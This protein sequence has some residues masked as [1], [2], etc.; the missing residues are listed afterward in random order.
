MKIALL[1]PIA[2]RTPPRH[3]GPWERV[4]S[5]LAEGLLEQGVE[6]T[7]FATGDSITKGKLEY[8]CP[9]PYE[10]NPQI[11]AKVWEYMHIAHLFEKAGQFDLI[12]NHYDFMPL[13]FCRL[14]S[15]PM[16]TT[17]HGFSSVKILPIY[18]E[19]NH[20]NYYISISNADRAPSL[21]YLDT[22]YHGLDLQEFDLVESP[23]EDLVFLGRIHPDKGTEEAIKI[24]QR[25]GRR[26]LIAG[27]I[28][29]QNYYNEI[30]VPQIDGEQIIYLG[31]VGPDK[32]N[33]LLGQAYA[34]LHPI[35]FDEPFGLSVVEAM[36][37]GTPV[38]AF[39]RGSMP[40]V[41]KDGETGFLVTDVE[42]ACQRLHHVSA[43]KRSHCRKWVEDNF[44]QERMVD[45]Y[46]HIYK[47]IVEGHVYGDHFRHKYSINNPTQPFH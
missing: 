46:L 17:I 32:R 37:C 20:D 19:Y 27:I 2:W 4:V 45:N 1:S 38:I 24:A 30:I 31:S 28:Q 8:I 21:D 36:A 33:H 34:F 43:I 13:A 15:T 40:E 12:H 11:D 9:F 42:E 35:N 18:Q 14:I 16:V 5:L 44:S 6:V 7:L 39:N 22:V 29:D 41:I 3:Y 47:L 26:L 23:G 25:C 10:E